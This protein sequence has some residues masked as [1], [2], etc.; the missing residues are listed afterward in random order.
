MTPSDT[1]EG[2][3]LAT[4]TRAQVHFGAGERAGVPCRWAVTVCPERACLR[5]SGPHGFLPGVG[6][7]RVCALPDWKAVTGPSCRN[8]IRL[9]ASFCSDS[10]CSSPLRVTAS[11]AARL[12]LPERGLAFSLLVCTGR[13]G[14]RA[15]NCTTDSHICSW[16]P[17]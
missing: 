1:E 17:L 10:V 4:A 5:L 6:G 3:A 13:H 8:E 12:R 14:Q 9:P 15:A 7:C 16:R 11:V 2:K